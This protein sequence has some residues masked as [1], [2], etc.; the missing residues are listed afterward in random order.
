MK[1]LILAATLAL[2]RGEFFTALVDL[3]NV[4][5]TESGMLDVLDNYIEQ[6][7]KSLQKLRETAADLRKLNREAL[8]D[9]ESFLAHPVHAFSTVKRFLWDWVLI[10]SAVRG[11]VPKTAYLTNMSEYQNY[12]P[13]KEDL[14]GAAAALLRLQD[15]YR[16][17]AKD[18]ADGN[19]E[20]VL[21][22]QPVM[23]AEDVFEVGRSAYN[24]NDHYHAEMW[25]REALRRARVEEK[26]PA[27]KPKIGTDRNDVDVP[28]ILDYLA[29]STYSLGDL[30]K[31]MEYTMELLEID[32]DHQRAK[33]NKDF[34]EYHILE[35]KKARGDTGDIPGGN[36]I[37]AS[38]DV[39]DL[40]EDIE[41]DDPYLQYSER[42]MYEALCRGDANVMKNLTDAKNA[43]ILKCS[44]QHYNKPHLYL[45]PAKEEIVFPDPLL[46]YYRDI[47]SD[48]E[49]V[50]IKKT[51]TPRLK[52]ATIQNSV[53][54]NLEFADYRISKSAWLK[55]DYDP[56]VYRVRR[57]V[58]HYTGLDLET[59]E[60]LQ[61]VNYGIGGHYEPHFDFAR[62]EEVNAFKD[63]GT[64]NRIATILF[65]LSAT[66][67]GGATVFPRAGARILP[68]K[69]SA[70]FWYNLF[71]NGD[72]NY[73]TRH[74]AC[75]V[76][77]GSKWVANIWI[78]E[79]GQEFRRK[80]GLNA[81]E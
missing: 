12:F 44:Y 61:V 28:T 7:Q 41:E 50:H 27:K 29:Y 74:A 71:R 16:L 75:P 58:A 25:L 63:L 54:G 76:L 48:E 45:Q 8:E 14:S 22:Y 32:P 65:Y 81:K 80:C 26:E 31:A 39:V 67:A 70:A 46:I 2:A 9:P 13:G 73:R 23:T 37:E 59:A 6:Q 38:E 66:E 52:R 78:H 4:L 5:Y 51:A 21:K 56:V 69:G 18:I 15:T 30:E 36:E 40:E 42:Q 33:N 64:G 43:R 11:D 49:I 62:K 60:D 24:G 55:D 47:V 10:E 68:E 79:K 17:E 19:I 72:G 34:F 3:E 35:K 77:S 53:T 57:R 20:G 1:V